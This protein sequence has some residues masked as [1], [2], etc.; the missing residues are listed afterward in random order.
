[1]ELSE[2]L[3]PILGDRVQLQQVILN[4]I[5]NAIEALSEV[6]DGSRELLI[7]T[8]E[9]VAE[10]LL[11]AVADSGPGLT[12]A[13]FERLFETFYTTKPSGLGMGLP[14]CRTII[15]AHGG[16]LWAEANVPRGA[17]FQF[18]VPIRPRTN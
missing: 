3:P 10:G 11:V 17:V 5:M 4:L 13:G 9:D 6:R 7:S 12:P 8:D 14:I 2:G 15:E 18:T 16:R 1:M